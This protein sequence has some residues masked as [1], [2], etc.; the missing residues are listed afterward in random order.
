MIGNQDGWL[1]CRR[2]YL[3]EPADP[4]NGA[5]WPPGYDPALATTARDV[6]SRALDACLAFARSGP[7]PDPLA[8]TSP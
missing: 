5:N 7:A 4:L 6:L 8:R 2:G 1:E 3:V